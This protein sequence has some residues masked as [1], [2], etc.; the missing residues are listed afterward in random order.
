MSATP[1][2]M[3][4]LGTP[5]P[6]FSLPDVVS[7]KNVSPADFAG[8]K[9]LLVMFICQH[10]PFVKHVKEELARLGRDFAKSDLGIV[11]IS[12]NDPA[13]SSEDTPEGLARMV[14]DWGSPI[15][16]VM[17][18][19]RRPRRAMKPRVR[20]ISSC[21]TKTEI[22]FIADSSTTAVRATASR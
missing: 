3:L 12:S 11:A 19:A 15:P 16:S 10:C 6:S 14:A 18:R 8:K 7:K 1:S 17:T 21:S 4:E 2:T 13:V 20:P 9:A 22:W 5:A